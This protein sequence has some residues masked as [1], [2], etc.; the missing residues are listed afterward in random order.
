MKDLLIK[1]ATVYDGDRNSAI[2]ADI[3]IK[4]DKIAEIAPGI[5]GDFEQTIDAKGMVATPGFIDVHRHNDIAALYDPDYGRLEL[6]QGLTSIVGGNCGLSPVPSREPFRDELYDFI[7]PCLGRGP[8][9]MAFPTFEAY[10]NAL[11]RTPSRIN[12]GLLAAF[13][14]IKTAVKGYTQTPFSRKEMTEAQAILRE[15]LAA[16]VVG[17]SSGIMYNPECYSTEDEYVE[18]LSAARDS[19]RPLTS[20]IRGEGN[21]LVSSVEEII[22]IT[23][24]TEL[25]LHI[26]H[27]K[28]TGIKN[29]GKSIYEAIEVIEHARQKGQAVTVD[30]YPYTGGSTTLMTL[31]PPSVLEPTIEGSLKKFSTKAGKEVLKQAI[32]SE[33]EGWDNMVTAIGWSRIL[34]SSVSLDGHKQF[35][36]LPVD[37]AAAL[38][39][40]SEPSDWICDL[41]YAEDAK[42]GIIVMSMEQADVD[43][44]MRLPYAVIISDALYGKTD[45]PHPRLYGSYPRII[46]EYV[47]ERGVLEFGTGI[48]KMTGLPAE[49]FGLSDR[50]LIQVGRKA[51]INIFDPAAV[52]DPATF[53]DPV[54]LSTGMH[55]VIVNGRP[56]WQNEK[57][58]GPGHGAV[59]RPSS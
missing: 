17:I 21:S 16:G 45:H 56:A 19:G 53:D 5:E 4:A 13:G 35:C 41:L 55:T 43:A 32:Y 15:G 54:R 28:S 58:E 29:W 33:H 2:E 57:A 12:T 49:I 48:H 7:E 40:Y 38:A 6:A 24:R 50:G 52:N 51:D 39:G 34:I 10:F 22:R 26:S 59:L 25:P 44:V 31:I 30:V 11:D 23:A 20:H 3:L 18:L 37:Q 8:A 27:F 36:G 42:V 47:R 14:A 9:D 46:R 1:S